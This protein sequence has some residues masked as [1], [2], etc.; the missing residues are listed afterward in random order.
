MD[1]NESLS[2]RRRWL[3]LQLVGTAEFHVLPLALGVGGMAFTL[4][5]LN[6]EWWIALL[7]CGFLWL[8]LV[9]FGAFMS[10][11]FSRDFRRVTVSERQI[12]LRRLI[13]GSRWIEV[14]SLARI[15][16]T[17]EDP[18]NVVFV[19]TSGPSLSLVASEWPTEMPDAIGA[20][21]GVEV[22]RLGDVDEDVGGTGENP[23]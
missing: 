8:P 11:M 5:N 13:V 9:A 14:G 2:F 21:L 20:Y 1:G 4:A 3:I 19:P 7:V 22:D 10:V 12:R 18:R 16:V 15:V 6:G 17:D 23:C